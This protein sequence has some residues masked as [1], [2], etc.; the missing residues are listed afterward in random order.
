MT[1][2]LRIA[3][4]LTY[5]EGTHLVHQLIEAVSNH[6]LRVFACLFFKLAGWDEEAIAH[7]LCWNSD[8]IKFYIRQALFQADEVGV[9]LF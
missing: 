5:L 8:T 4:L 7:E 6:S 1:S 9:S 3:A 2:A